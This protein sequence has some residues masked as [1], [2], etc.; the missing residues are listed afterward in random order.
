MFLPRVT[1]ADGVTRGWRQGGEGRRIV[2]LH[3]TGT[4][5]DLWGAVARELASRFTVVAADLPGMGQTPLQ[6]A[7]QV[8]LDGY[9]AWLRKLIEN[10][11]GEAVVV[12]I[13]LAGQLVL[14]LAG[15]AAAGLRAG[16]AFAPTGLARA[17]DPAIAWL[18][19]PL[20][21]EAVLAVARWGGV[22]RRLRRM[23]NLPERVPGAFLAGA[24]ALLSQRSQRKS[25]LAALRRLPLHEDDPQGV[26]R[27]RP[28]GVP[29]VLAWGEADKVLPFSLGE[30]YARILGLPLWRINY[31]GHHVPLEQPLWAAS[32]IA[33]AADPR[34]PVHVDLRGFNG[35]ACADYIV[36]TEKAAAR[37]RTG[38][39]IV[40]HTRY[41]C[42]G[43]DAET[44]TRM[45][46]KYELLS[47]TYIEDA[48][49]IHVRLNGV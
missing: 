36:R 44:W 3:G 13:D 49:R 2:L 46:K 48:W 25:L 28:K 4:N 35:V 6:A 14:R 33:H 29:T 10:E 31:A 22:R 5:A 1:L 27:L 15:E 37:L 40:I 23:A 8:S 32:I 20:I 7:P 11:G 38:D 24:E 45:R 39:E 12:G 43:D 42:A 19:R 18:R 9:A 30:R 17:I 41:S 16:V 47:T 26:E 34:E 21:G